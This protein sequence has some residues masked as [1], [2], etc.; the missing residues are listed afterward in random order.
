MQTP[1]CLKVVI[2][3]SYNTPYRNGLFNAIN[4]FLDIDLHICYIGVRPEARK[5][6]EHFESSFREYYVEIKKVSHINY[7]N[8]VVKINSFDF[9]RK[10]IKINPDIIIT[11]FG[12]IPLKIIL[13]LILF[14]KFKLISW[15]ETTLITSQ[16]VKYLKSFHKPLNNIFKSYIVPGILAKEYLI[17]SGFNVKDNIFFAQNSVDEIF[18]IT[19]DEVILKHTDNLPIKFIY[20]GSYVERKGI[21]I[22]LQAF[23]LIADYYNIELHL[24]GD[25]PIQVPDRPYFFNH[26]FINKDQIFCILNKCHILVLPSLW[27]CNPLVVIEASKCGLILMLSDGV[28]NYPEMIN[29][30]GIVFQRNNQESMIVAFKYLLNLDREKLIKMSLKSLD[31]SNFISHETSANAFRE[32]IHYRYNRLNKLHLAVKILRF[33]FMY[34]NYK[35]NK[36]KITL[37]RFLKKDLI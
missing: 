27:D 17:Y 32:A 33:F 7:E 18:R 30:N 2:I 37:L 25:G 28:G 24:I 8:S 3:Q 34:T 9:I 12:Q 20:I 26:G 11:H 35:T 22:L 21:S 10:I 15:T 16:G 29:E 36:F 19:R 13:P 14:L 31:N 5:W 4:S 6:E 23:E 1:G